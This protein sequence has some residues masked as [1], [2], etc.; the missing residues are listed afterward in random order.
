MTVVTAGPRQA[1]CAP[2]A[3]GPSLAAH[4]QAKFTTASTLQLTGV[5][6][7]VQYHD[8]YDKGVDWA[9]LMLIQSY[10]QDDVIQIIIPG[11]PACQWSA[12]HC[13]FES[14]IRL[15]TCRITMHRQDG[16]EQCVHCHPPQPT[17]RA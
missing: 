3:E 13:V 16:A 10:H 15:C 4:A 9:P 2:C 14:C 1:A 11:T 6:S 8:A 17:R 7:T 5:S 12:W